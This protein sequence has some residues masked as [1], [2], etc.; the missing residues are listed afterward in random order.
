M[1]QDNIHFEKKSCSRYVFLPA[2]LVPVNP[3]LQVHCPVEASQ[4]PWD[5]QLSGQVRSVQQNSSLGKGNKVGIIKLVHLDPQVNK[6]KVWPYISTYKS[7]YLIGSVLCKIGVF[8]MSMSIEAPNGSAILM[9]LS[10]GLD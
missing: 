10:S 1:K 7:L 8:Q 9:A 3:V 4:V 2:Q 5:E 6:A